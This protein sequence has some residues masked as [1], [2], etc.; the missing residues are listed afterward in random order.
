MLSVRNRPFGRVSKPKRLAAIQ[1][2]RSRY[3][4]LPFANDFG[5]SVHCHNYCKAIIILLKSA[6]IGIA[7]STPLSSPNLSVCL[8]DCLLLSLPLYPS[9][10][11][12]IHRSIYLSRSFASSLTL[13]LS[14]YQSVLTSN[15]VTISYLSYLTLFSPIMPNVSFFVA[16]L[17]YDVNA[18]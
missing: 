3:K 13:Y 8:S 4:A 6:C 15:S 18:L 7:S 17:A 14:L 9:I 10:Y 5:L 11:L 16:K 2:V 1:L 12:S